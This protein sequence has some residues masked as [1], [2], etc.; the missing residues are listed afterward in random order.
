MTTRDVG[1]AEAVAFLR[2]GGLVAIPTETVYG[3]AARA[4]D[5]TA[6]DAIFAAKGRPRAH[7]LIVHLASADDLAAWAAEVPS[8][9]RR[10]ADVLWP[11]PLTLVV[12]RAAHVLDAVTGGRDTVALRVPRHPLALEV[13]RGVGIGLAAPSANLFGRVSPT[14]ASHVRME[15]F[16]RDVAVLD[17]GACEVG[18]ESTILDVSG[19]VPTLLRPGGV[20]AET[21]DAILGAPIADGRG[22][23]SRAPGMLASHYAPRARVIAVRDLV[24]ARERIERERGRIAFVGRE[25]IEG[26]RFVEQ[27]SDLGERA[28]ALYATLRSLDGE[29]IDVIVVELPSEAGLGVAIADRLRRASRQ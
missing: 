19:D 29:A 20:S 10:L 26:A 2:A 8:S 4:D 11:G 6:V 17:G 18:L 5:A 25:P 27:P 9:A 16:A 24:E 22:G 7:P 15:N 23:E 1:S 3:L 21:I 13:I 14:S 28:R 12:K